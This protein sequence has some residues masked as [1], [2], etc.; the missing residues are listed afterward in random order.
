LYVPLA[1]ENNI[2]MW[3]W[4]GYRIC[5]NDRL[6]KAGNYIGTTN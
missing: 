2:T 5:A 4:A 3:S 1:I 6:V